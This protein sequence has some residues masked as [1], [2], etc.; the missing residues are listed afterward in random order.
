MLEV[1]GSG[2]FT[3]IRPVWVGDL[4]TTVDQKIQISIVENLCFVLFSAVTDIATNLLSA[5]ADSGKKYFFNRTKTTFKQ[6]KN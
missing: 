2:V 5:V 4:G 1:F 3:H 6:S